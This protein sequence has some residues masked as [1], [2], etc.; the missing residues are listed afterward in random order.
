VK[1]AAYF[2]R[3]TDGLSQDWH[4]RIWL[5]PPYGGAQALFTDHL[6]KE[7]EAGN[8]T[9]AILLVNSNS[10]DTDWFQPLWDHLLCFT[11]SRINFLS[12]A[13][14]VQA[15]STHGSVFIYLGPDWDSFAQEFEA[16]GNIVSRYRL[17]A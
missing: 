5:N 17:S 7:Y 3:D 8:L 15:G 14:E 9:A 12:P 1:A 6:L 4:G 11:R 10:T 16:F 2:D 13:G